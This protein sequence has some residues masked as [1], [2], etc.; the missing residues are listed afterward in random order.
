MVDWL[1]INKQVHIAIVIESIRQN[2]PKDRKRL[3]LVFVTKVEDSLQ[4]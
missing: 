1:E 2:R 3:Y 4:I